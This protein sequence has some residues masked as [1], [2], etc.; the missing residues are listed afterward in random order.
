MTNVEFD[1]QKDLVGQ[2]LS[3]NNPYQITDRYD[4]GNTQMA[5]KIA[6]IL[7]RIGLAKT[8][9]GASAILISVAV[10]FFLIS[11]AILAYFVFGYNP[12]KPKPNYWVPA[13]NQRPV[14]L[15]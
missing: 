15:P 4:S 2:E 9:N 3:R 5:P 7:T 1:E 6:R 11:I 10:L 13:E 14:S 8:E 12:F